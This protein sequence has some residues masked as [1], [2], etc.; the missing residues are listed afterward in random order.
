MIQR[1]LLSHRLTTL[2]QDPPP[3][4]VFEISESAIALARTRKFSGVTQ[5]PLPPE[6]VSA[7]PVRDNILAP[8]A[9]AEA[10]RAITPPVPG[11]KRRS[12][13]LILPDHSARLVVVD[14]DSFPDKPDEQ[15]SL[16]RFRMKRSVPF[17]VETAALSFWRQSSPGGKS[18]EVVVAVTP[19]EIVARYEA[20]FRALNIQTGFVTISS[21]AAIELVSADGIS[22]L[23][24]IN[25]RILTVLVLQHGVLKL[26]RSLELTE[27]SL[28]EIAADLF[29][30]FI[31]IEDNFQSKAAR[32][33]LCGFGDLESS[34]TSQFESDLAIP[35]EPLRSRVAP[36]N[37]QNA[38]LL[39]YVQ[40]ISAQAV[41]A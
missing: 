21:L 18:H 26:V 16:V 7:S 10:V 35:V 13:A 8:E 14:F 34:A 3:E 31:Y 38:G 29:P 33:L 9:L 30:T 23:A 22:V 39:G 20:P 4:L 19:L 32:L 41:A 27:S 40:S 12:A 11:R 17:D 28:A 6:T 2:F 5:H 37:G 36:L 15:E 1:P 25:G 24:K